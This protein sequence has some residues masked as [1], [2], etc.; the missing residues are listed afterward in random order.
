VIS[1]DSETFGKLYSTPQWNS[2]AE[3]IFVLLD[4]NDF[5]ARQAGS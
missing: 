5:S 1:S 4:M 3:C 2:S